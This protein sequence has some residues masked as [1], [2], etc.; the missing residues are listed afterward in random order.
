MIWFLLQYVLPLALLDSFY[1][2]IKQVIYDLGK[3]MR[4]IKILNAWKMFDV[5]LVALLIDILYFTT[6]NFNIYY[7]PQSGWSFM[8]FYCIFCRWLSSKKIH[9]YTRTLSHTPSWGDW[10]VWTC[11][12]KVNVDDGKE[13][14]FIEGFC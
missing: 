4:Y 13:I 6:L 5:H 1:E 9:K 14:E 11:K 3:Y 12:L 10:I 2:N 7:M 8:L